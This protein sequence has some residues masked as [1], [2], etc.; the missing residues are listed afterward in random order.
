[1]TDTDESKARQEH[2]SNGSDTYISMSMHVMLGRN[3]LYMVQE[4]VWLTSCVTGS[5]LFLF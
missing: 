2:C 3:Y 5:R 4:G 1:M